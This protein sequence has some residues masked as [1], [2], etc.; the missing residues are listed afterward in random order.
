MGDRLRLHVS[1][2]WGKAKD[3]HHGFIPFRRRSCLS[4]CA[5]GVHQPRHDR[6]LM[7]LSVSWRNQRANQRSE[8]GLPVAVFYSTEIANVCAGSRRRVDVERHRGSGGKLKGT[9]QYGI[10]WFSQQTHDTG[11]HAIGWLFPFFSTSLVVS[12]LFALV[13]RT[14]RNHGTLINH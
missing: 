1:D 11:E 8:I 13:Q 14:S 4:A 6:C 10:G 2:I 3:F 12:P 5:R 7:D 9:Q